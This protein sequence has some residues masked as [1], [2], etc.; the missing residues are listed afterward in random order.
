MVGSTCV[1]Y[2]RPQLPPSAA[3]TQK[4]VGELLH[5]GTCVSARCV[6]VEAWL[7]CWPLRDTLT[8]PSGTLAIHVALPPP[9][10]PGP[11]APQGLGQ[12]ECECTEGKN[13]YG[14]FCR[15]LNGFRER[16]PWN[17]VP[18]WDRDKQCFLL[19]S[20]WSSGTIVAQIGRVGWPSELARPSCSYVGG[21]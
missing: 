19:S 8:L 16:S 11:Q 14:R 18:S 21:F 13:H 4:F 1:V 6:G 7:R 17:Q 2:T 12:M 5:S 10:L 20:M 15:L 9:T 3:H